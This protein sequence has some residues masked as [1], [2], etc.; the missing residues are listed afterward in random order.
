MTQDST[1]KTKNCIVN[2]VERGF[3]ENNYVLLEKTLLQLTS[4][5]GLLSTS[6]TPPPFLRPWFRTVIMHIRRVS[7]VLSIPS[8]YSSSAINTQIQ[9]HSKLMVCFRFI[10]LP[11]FLFLTLLHM[12]LT[13][14]PLCPPPPSPHPPLPSGHHHSCLCVHGGRMYVLGLI[15]S[16]SCIQFT[17]PPPL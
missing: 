17:P 6:P 12:S 13:S 2:I 10:L 8:S 3:K 15:L 9:Q 1:L 5:D 4:F 11:L 14:D 7:H 16:P